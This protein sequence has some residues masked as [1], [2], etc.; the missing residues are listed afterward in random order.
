VTFLT[1]T[2]H[3]DAYHAI[4]LLQ[5]PKE[6]I[7]KFNVGTPDRILRIVVGLILIGLAA[8]GTIGVWG[9]I[10][11]VPLVTGAIKFCPAYA[12]FGASTCSME[13]K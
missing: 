8:S 13:Q 5:F 4:P 2:I 11:V 10:G 6:H 1:D 3:N 7:M 9:W 12:I